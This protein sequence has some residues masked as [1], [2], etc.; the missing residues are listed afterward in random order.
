MTLTYDL[1]DP[2]ALLGGLPFLDEEFAAKRLLAA[3]AAARHVTAER[4]G[5]AGRITDNA[6]ETWLAPS[7]ALLL[8]GGQPIPA[9]PLA[10]VQKDQVNG[11]LTELGSL[12]PT[13][14]ALTTLPVRY[15]CLHVPNGAISASSRAWPQHVLLAEDA[16]ATPLELR[17]QIT[18]EL[19]HQWLYLMEELWRIELPS[20]RPVTLPSGT[21]NRSPSEVLGAAHVAAV[22]TRLYAEAGDAPEGR[23]ERLAAYQAGCLALLDQIA[24]DLTDLGRDIARHLKEVA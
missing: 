8:G 15:A 10:P 20:A 14:T 24:D 6:L 3:V 7:G 4:Q 11:A 18:H 5:K 9:I 16:F 23:L 13:W 1:S 22:L 21:A 2:L 12:I 17:E 19:A